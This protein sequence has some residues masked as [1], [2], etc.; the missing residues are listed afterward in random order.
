MRHR[1]RRRFLLFF[2]I[3]GTAASA[4][5]LQRADEPARDALPLLSGSPDYYMEGFQ[6][7]VIGDNEGLRYHLDGRSLK[8]FSGEGSAVVDKPRLRVYGHGS[9]DWELSA[10]V[11]Y[12]AGSGEP[13]LLEKDV[14]ANRVT[15]DSL[16]RL[17]IRTDR[18]TIDSS[19]R[20]MET[21]EAVTVEHFNGL[22]LARG[23]KVD[24]NNRTMNLHAEVHG[25]YR[26]Y[27][28]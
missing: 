8:H 23:M 18:L 27:P 26:T 12:L 25:E 5:L 20:F 17:E 2:L 4:W 22:T 11:A 6:V 16:Q 13:V 21:D 24:L 14:R 7:K 1:S 15:M 9:E 3:T 28:Q 10:G 19:G